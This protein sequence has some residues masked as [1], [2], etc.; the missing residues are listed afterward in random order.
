MAKLLVLY[1]HPRNVDAFERY[2]REMH[3][4]LALKVP[5]VRTIAVSD[6][7]VHSMTGAS[8]HYLIAS[9]TFDS[10]ADLQAG[11]S[12]PEG[13]VAAADLP[14]FATGGVTLLTFDEREVFVAESQPP[15]STP[16]GSHVGD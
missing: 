11:L 9:L 14:N 7:P 13:Q 6:G 8:E 1:D 10:M 2:Y 12:S 15:T 16:G 3:I 5:G 4:P